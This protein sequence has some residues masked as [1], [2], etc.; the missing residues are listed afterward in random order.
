MNAAGIDSTASER[1]ARRRRLDAICSLFEAAW[2]TAG[3]P[4]TRP[5]LDDDLAQAVEPERTALLRE[6]IPLDAAYRRLAGEDPRPH[7]YQA[8]FPAFDALCN[9]FHAE[10]RRCFSAEMK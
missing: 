7:E 1:F 4:G 5:R 10:D 6:L 8:R 3:S 2:K 9:R